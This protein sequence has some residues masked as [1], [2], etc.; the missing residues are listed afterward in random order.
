MEGSSK[1][2]EPFLDLSSSWVR[3]PGSVTQNLLSLPQGQGQI[4]DFLES[5]GV[6]VMVYM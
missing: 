6:L 2:L 4:L 1:S 3:I 5:L